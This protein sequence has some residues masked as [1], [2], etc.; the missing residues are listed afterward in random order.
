[1]DAVVAFTETSLGMLALRKGLASPC[2]HA[3][4]VV[5]RQGDRLSVWQACCHLL[6]VKADVGVVDPPV[7]LVAQVLGGVI[8][9]LLS[10]SI[11]GPFVANEALRTATRPPR[12]P[13]PPPPPG[14]RAPAPASAS[15]GKLVG[16]NDRVRATLVHLQRQQP[17]QASSTE[18]T[19]RRLTPTVRARASAALALA[20]VEAGFGRDTSRTSGLLPLKKLYLLALAA[21]LPTA[22]SAELVFERGAR[23]EGGVAAATGG[24]IETTWVD[25]TGGALIT[26]GPFFEFTKHAFCRALLEDWAARDSVQAALNGRSEGRQGIMLHAE[27]TL[28]LTNRSKAMLNE[29][30]MLVRNQLLMDPRSA[31]RARKAVDCFESWGR[32]VYAWAGASMLWTPMVEHLGSAPKR[33]REAGSSGESG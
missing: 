8:G 5:G 18:A 16:I 30:A 20:S 19:H 9:E 29:V 15:K 31:P 7:A 21:E 10:P 1:M 11:G 24:Q 12:P 13:P 27:A 22:A 4:Q 33:K 32:G 17:A 6:R 26:T 23:G 3:M 28:K 25:A 2:L 14:R